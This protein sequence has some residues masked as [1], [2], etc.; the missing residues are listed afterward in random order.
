MCRKSGRFSDRGLAEPIRRTCLEPTASAWSC[1]SSSIRLLSFR[2]IISVTTKPE[3]STSAS[4][5]PTLKGSSPASS[6]TADDNGRKFGGSS[7]G[8]PTGSYI[9][10]I[11]SAT[12]LRLCPT[13]TRRLSLT[14]P[15]GASTAP[16]R[17]D[18]ALCEPAFHV[19]GCTVFGTLC[20]GGERR[21]RRRRNDLSLRL[22][23][24]RDQGG[25]G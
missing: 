10:R 9:A 19:S 16:P 12:S 15:V 5:I 14:C 13:P 11:R 21:L 25:G 2:R 17:H 7:K 3:F 22:C 6:N 24:D 20:G 18:Q 1:F 8:G 4:P 23:R